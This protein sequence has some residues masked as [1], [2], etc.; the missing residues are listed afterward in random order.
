VYAIE[1]QLI[2]QVRQQYVSSV[3]QA[4][5]SF[6]TQVK[7]QGYTP[8]VLKELGS[9]AAEWKQLQ[10]EAFNVAIQSPE[11]YPEW[12]QQHSQEIMSLAGMK[13]VA[14]L[15]K[16][17]DIHS[18]IEQAAQAKARGEAIT[19]TAFAAGIGAFVAAPLTAIIGAAGGT[20][21]QTVW[22]GVTEKRLPTTEETITTAGFSAAAS[23]AVGPLLS[24]APLP[25]FLT[26]P[27]VSGAIGR[28]GT[29]SAASTG[30][31][32]AAAAVKGEDILKGAAAGALAGAAAGAVFEVAGVAAGFIRKQASEWLTG[33]YLEKGPLEWKGVKEEL[34]MKVTGAKPFKPASSIVD[35]PDFPEPTAGSLFKQQQ[36]WELAESPGTSAYLATK[37]TGGTGQR[38]SEWVMEHWLVRATGGLSYALVQPEL[39]SWKP[40]AEERQLPQL[41]K[42]EQPPA[43]ISPTV[44]IITPTIQPSK[45][46]IPRIDVSPVISPRPETKEGERVLP[47]VETLPTVLPAQDT[48]T[49]KEVKPRLTP[50]VK[51][52]DWE[53]KAEQQQQ[54]SITP[55][56]QTLTG[57]KPRLTPHV[58]LIDWEEGVQQPIIVPNIT[59][60]EPL[61]EEQRQKIPAIVPV[62]PREE[63]LPTVSIL[64]REKPQT[65]TVKVPSIVPSVLPRGETIFEQTPVSET[66]PVLEVSQIQTAKTVAKTLQQT[67]PILAPP[68]QQKFR[69]PLPS[70]GS[71]HEGVR[72]PDFGRLLFGGKYVKRHE[73]ALPSQ[74]AKQVLTVSARSKAKTGVGVSSSLI[75]GKQSRRGAGAGLGGSFSS[76]VFD[77]GGRRRGSRKSLLK[78]SLAEVVFG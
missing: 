72:A 12:L 35:I 34:V 11:K 50:Q 10:L 58:R 61:K 76:F 53:E 26:E 33:K 5:R 42:L 30:M 4:H 23:A 40:A 7:T 9:K 75:F 78:G 36:A 17:A 24:K 65:E 28:I 41:P 43:T 3:E 59:P 68:T 46:E 60:Q 22:T 2:E 14:S 20:V 49:Q 69:G 63:T 48:I 47:R 74:V 37:Y 15:A 13:G 70:F 77:V 32:A 1:Q 55:S 31:G 66:S 16:L 57:P 29:V 62:L 67:S 45:I 19:A 51:L 6:I 25:E 71:R 21:A 73:I 44:P 39:Q 38:V 64:P 8:Q 18:Q 54:L 56:T 27:G 52:I